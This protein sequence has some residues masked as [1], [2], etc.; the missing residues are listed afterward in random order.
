MT[1]RGPVPATSA[2]LPGPAVAIVGP[3]ASGK[4]ALALALARL[5]DAEVV[6]V[7]AM[8]VYRGMDVGTAK[9]TRAERATVP[10]HLVDIVDPSEEFSVAGF[11]RLARG[12]IDGI[13]QRGRLPL[14][15]G[16]SGL[17]FHSIVDDFTFPPTDPAARRALE[18]EAA[19]LGGPAM[20]ERL[21]A[22]DPEA[23]ARIQ[24]ANLRRTIRALEVIALT[25]R[26]F[27]SFRAA[28]DHPVSRYDVR[29][30]GLDPGR[31]ELGERIGARV[32]AMAEAGLVDE[33]RRL[34]AG[35]LS[36]TARQALGY[37][38]LLDAFETGGEVGDALEAVVHRT[39]QYARRQ[40]SWFRRDTRILWSTLPPGPAQLVWARGELEPWL[41][42]RRRGGGAAGKPGTRQAPVTAGSGGQGGSPRGG[43]RPA[44]G[45]MTAPGGGTTRQGRNVEF[46]KAHGTGNDFVVIEDLIDEF[47]LSAEQV[48]AICDRHFGIGADGVIRI[49]PG[50]KAPFFMDYRNADG[51]I[52]EMCGNGV[53]VVGKYLGDRGH[54]NLEFD[55]ETRA[56]VKHLLL[57]WNDGGCVDGVTVDMGP[58]AFERAALPMAGEGFALETIL[59]VDGLPVTLTGVSMGNPHAVVFVG[60]V[61]SAPVATLGARIETHAAFPNHTNV[62][63]VEVV[64]ERRLRQRTWERGVGET[65]ACGTGACAV[66]VASMRLGRVTGPTVTVDLRGGPLELTWRPGETVIM[67]GPA[68]EV[69]H[70][71]ISPSLLGLSVA[72]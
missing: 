62:E 55:L 30:L 57:H 72:G 32:A 13:L 24:P 40:L 53:R 23:A 8:L 65:L 51:S 19:A 7:D 17:Y 49:A 48:R 59:D 35:P 21:A 28:M 31:A 9:P 68:H 3:T 45:T 69:A 6:S 26:R 54:V 10:H 56:G 50:T 60:D 33:V 1:A 42:R 20:H 5:L 41:A 12:A 36:R 27:S 46:V 66:A 25:G 18:D 4:T 15:V 58:P 47:D 29:V 52:A 14:L 70:G 2:D 63:F 16:G 43:G 34:A 64:G 44:A 38:E 67:T 37:K 61:D 71:T 11:Q 22:L 39:R